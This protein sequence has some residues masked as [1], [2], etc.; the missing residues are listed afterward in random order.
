MTQEKDF[1]WLRERLTKPTHAGNWHWVIELDEVLAVLRDQEGIIPEALTRHLKDTL[2]KMHK[3]Q[4]GNRAKPMNKVVHEG[5]VAGSVLFLI[6]NHFS[7]ED[8]RTKVAEITGTNRDDVV[9]WHNTA[10][11]APDLTG[12]KYHL[13][14]RYAAE[15]ARGSLAENY[16]RK[17]NQMS[18]LDVV[19]FFFSPD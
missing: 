14:A 5:A 8:A 1:D 15:N 17:H 6:D 18:H 19:R 2:T 9:T 7:P 10:V 11:K 4:A 13:N 3:S 12:M 16:L